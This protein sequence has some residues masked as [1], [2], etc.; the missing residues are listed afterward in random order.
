[1][2]TKILLLT[3]SFYCC[4]GTTA[5][6]QTDT[7]TN[8]KII[9]L[10]K[11]KLESSVII[12]KIKT[13]VTVFDVSTDALI[14]LSD[15]GVA[16]DVINEMMKSD[17]KRQSDLANKKDLNDP[18][19]KR[20]PGI[21]YYNPK[22][23]AKPVK[24]VDPTISSTT[25]SGGFGTALAQG[26]TYGIAKDK[27]TS[28]IAG[29]E[30]RM[31]IFNTNPVFYFYFESNNNPDAGNWFFAAATSPNEFAL[32]KMDEKKNSREMQVGNA[33]AYGS[34][35]GIPDKVKVAFEY[36]E[37]A[38]GVYKVT[39]L[40]PLKEGEYCFLYAS[41]TPTRYSNNK[42]FDFGIWKEK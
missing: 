37:E 32:V 33:N 40:Q 15:N 29:N 14:K 13:S 3:A 27:L 38:A 35:S 25:K 5:R 12:N 1:M 20:Q 41:S 18:K 22:D 17:T 11:L 16:A 28:S 36:A 19:T 10:S 21:Y 6:A 4:T 31:K 7:L 23:T 9:K 39:F 34:S 26:M 30:S 24:R 42:V 2:K 8:E